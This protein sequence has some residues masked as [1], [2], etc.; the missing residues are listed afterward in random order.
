MEVVYADGTVIEADKCILDKEGVTLQKGFQQQSQ[1][2]QGQS[3]Q[4]Q[5]QSG[6]QQG[7]S[8]Q[9]QSGQ[10]QSQSGQ[11][12]GQSKQQSQSQQSQSGQKQGQSGQQKKTYRTIGFVQYEKLRYIINALGDQIQMGQGTAQQ[13]KSN[14]KSS[15]NQKAT[16]KQSKKQEAKAKKQ[17][18][19]DEKQ[20][21]K[22]EKQ[23]EQAEGQE[24]KA[25]KQESKK[26]SFK[27]EATGEPLAIKEMQVNAPGIDDWHKNQ[28]YLVFTNAGS[29]PLELSGWEVHNEAGHTYRFPDGFVLDSGETTTL[30]SG[31]GDDTDSDLYWDSERAIWKNGSDTVTVKNAD[32]DVILEKSYS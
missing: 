1:S 23:E 26:A 28:E 31:N 18:K 4:K 6:Q 15:T 10:K 24:A 7:Q 3:G 30:H 19:K 11:Q 25:E 14:E 22:A 21:A 29:N 9:G 16:S 13:S 20:E 12:Q 32:G 17:E 2:Q 27:A 5:G 8:Q